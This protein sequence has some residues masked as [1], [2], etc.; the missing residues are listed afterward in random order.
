MPAC[1][2]L[3]VPACLP[4]PA[5]PC[6]PASA[7]LSLPAPACLPLPACLVLLLRYTGLCCKLYISKAPP[8]YAVPPANYSRNLAAIWRT[9]ACDLP[10]LVPRLRFLDLRF[11]DS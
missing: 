9:L 1:P 4:L 8:R 7:R 10:S 3:P 6:P 5:C 2:Y 11:L